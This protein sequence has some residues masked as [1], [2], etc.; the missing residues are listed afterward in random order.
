[1]VVYIHAYNLEIF[2][3][4]N[5]G[6]TE[7]VC[8]YIERIFFYINLVA[9][10]GFFI[11]SGYLFFITLRKDNIQEKLRRRFHSLVIPYIVWNTLFIVYW[12]I[13]CSVPVI[14]KYITTK[15]SFDTISIVK[16]LTIA[17][18]NA[19]LWFVRN[20]CVVFATT[21]LIWLII[22]KKCWGG[23]FLSVLIAVCIGIKADEFHLIYDICLFSMGGY[24]SYWFNEGFIKPSKIKETISL[25][26][27][28]VYLLLCIKNPEVDVNTLGLSIVIKVCLFFSFWYAIDLMK[29][30]K[31]TILADYRTFI[32]F[33]HSLFLESIEK[34]ILITAGMSSVV[35]LLDYI[36]APVICILVMIGLGSYIRKH[37]PFMWMMLC[38]DKY[39][40][41][42]DA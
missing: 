4:R 10:P 14:E 6:G 13:L 3:I 37:I 34:L 39:R 12:W 1:M 26:F 38:G 2:S 41:F 16:Y 21:P 9:V 36:L 11:L 25:L 29:F 30:Q 28:A 17:P 19:P 18:V 40:R 31:N 20:L 23:I 33:G 24:L 15:R 22:R 7:S 42:H 8:Y 35:A 27:I 32:Y 5:G